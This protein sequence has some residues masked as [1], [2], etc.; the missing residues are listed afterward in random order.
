MRVSD[1]YG[2]CTKVHGS[3]QRAEDLERLNEPESI[4]CEGHVSI[5]FS[6]LGDLWE[7]VFYFHSNGGIT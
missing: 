2:I 5:N 3:T 4:V 6:Q 1:S 7:N